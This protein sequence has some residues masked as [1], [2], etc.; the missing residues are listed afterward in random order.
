MDYMTY[1]N[2]FYKL[3]YTESMTKLNK[4]LLCINAK[5]YT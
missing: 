4:K 5:N 2:Y 3:K 1:L